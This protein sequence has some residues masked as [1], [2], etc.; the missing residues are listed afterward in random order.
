M[1]LWESIALDSQEI[2]RKGKVSLI[3][4]F[5]WKLTSSFSSISMSNLFKMLQQVI[6]GYRYQHQT[7]TYISNL[8]L[9]IKMVQLL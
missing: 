2:I 5:F 4:S 8:L 6:S 7:K 1:F 3:S 9:D